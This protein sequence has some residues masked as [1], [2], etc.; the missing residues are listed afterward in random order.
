MKSICL[1][2]QNYYDIDPRVRRKAEFLQASGFSVDVIALL[3]S[4]REPGDY[5]LNGVTVYPI[6]IAKERGSFLRYIYEYLVFFISAFGKVSG[7]MF[8]NKYQVIDVNTLPDFLVFAAFLPKLLGAKVVLDM[9]EVMP[10]FYMS[11][12]EVPESHWVIR[13]I[14]VQEWLSIRFADQVLVINEPIKSV[15]V[16]RGLNPSKTTILL[17]SVDE[18][19]FSSNGNVH[20]GVRPEPGRFVMAYHG[21]LTHIYGLDIALRGFALAH[22]QMPGAE[23]WVIGDGPECPNLERIAAESG[24]S[25]KVKFLGAMPQQ[26]VAGWL[27]QSDVGVLATRQ[28]RFLDL[29]FSNKLPEYIVMGKP[30]IASRL[31]TI[32]H[33]FSEGALAYFKPQD[34]SDLANKM[35]ELYKEPLRRKMLAETAAKEYKAINWDV[36]KERYYE[37]IDTL[38]NSRFLRQS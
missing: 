22:S 36:M 34:P 6:K 23:F 20:E 17:N 16:K 7:L 27:A 10:E 18:R 2:V 31:K 4:N 28:D 12:F 11:K 1:I 32:N 25:G 21:T 15:L 13:A 30:V 8:K 29:S 19:L 26:D 35:L 14:K 24:L 3:P 37:V 33:Y 5:K 38:A 9:H